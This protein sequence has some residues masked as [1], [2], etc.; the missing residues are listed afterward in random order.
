MRLAE[1][2]LENS[3]MKTN[4]QMS[5]ILGL[6]ALAV[7]ATACGSSTP[8]ASTPPATAPA[9]TTPAAT[10]SATTSTSPAASGSAAAITTHGEAFFSAKTPVAKRVSLL[11]DGSQFESIIKGQAGTGLAATASAKVVSVSMTT[12]SQATVKYDILVS[13]STALANQ[14]GTAVLESG[15]W[16]VGVASFCGLLKLEELKTLPAACSSAG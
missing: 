15:T 10:P 13:G 9:A 14:T 16:K 7:V 4:R 3:C 12:P 11:Q 8:S 6:C 1:S 2:E 5:A